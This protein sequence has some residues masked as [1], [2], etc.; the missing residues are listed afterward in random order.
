MRKDFRLPKRVLD[1]FEEAALALAVEDLMWRVEKIVKEAGVEGEI[2]ILQQGNKLV[3]TVVK[4]GQEMMRHEFG[5]E[6]SPPHG[7]WRKY[8][9]E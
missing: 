4:G 6:K 1:S 5:S 8:L 7:L 2:V 3:V 9:A